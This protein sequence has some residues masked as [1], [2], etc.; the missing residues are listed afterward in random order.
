MSTTAG[1][2]S[3]STST[4]AARSSAAARLAATQTA[5]A[6]PFNLTHAMTELMTLGLSLPDIVATVTSNPARML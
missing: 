1:S 3:N 5:I 6:S 4:E 2:S